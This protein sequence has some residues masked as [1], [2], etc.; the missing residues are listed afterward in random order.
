MSWNYGTRG[1]S[2][3]VLIKIVIHTWAHI[4]LHMDCVMLWF[5]VVWYHHKTKHNIAVCVLHVIHRAWD[6]C[7][8]MGLSAAFHVLSSRLL[9]FHATNIH[10]GCT[11]SCINI[12][13]HHCTT[14]L[15]ARHNFIKLDTIRSFKNCHTSIFYV[16]FLDIAM[17]IRHRYSWCCEC[18]NL[19]VIY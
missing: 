1:I 10:M 5:V 13:M 6:H 4:C 8:L 2:Y 19:S 11:V 12:D 18:S 14:S 3:Y 15:I 7:L 17:Q 9:L 16:S